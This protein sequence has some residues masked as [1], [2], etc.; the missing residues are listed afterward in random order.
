MLKK[1]KYIFNFLMVCFCIA[2]PAFASNTDI[3]MLNADSLKEGPSINLITDDNG[4]DAEEQL[5]GL[6]QNDQKT[7]LLD[8]CISIGCVLLLFGLGDLI[9]SFKDDNAESKS[10]AIKIVAVGI[11]LIVLPTTIKLFTGSSVAW[12]PDL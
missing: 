10:R 11:M 2:V 3:P 6:L 9:F 5:K 1:I 7:G 8:I 4:E 12:M